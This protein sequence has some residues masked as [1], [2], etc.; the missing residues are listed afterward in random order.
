MA[1]AFDALDQ[2]IPGTSGPLSPTTT[3]QPAPTI[4]SLRKAPPPILNIPPNED[5]LLHYLTSSLMKNGE[6]Q[7]AARITA[8]TL[9]Y[10]HTFTRAPPLPI[11]RE[12]II[13]ASPAIRCFSTTFGSKRVHTP[14]ALSEKQR[15]RFGVEWILK[16]SES[17][18][19]RT[20]E[21]RLAREMVAVV[22]GT[23]DALK[24]KEEAH[25]F[26]MVNRGNLKIRM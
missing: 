4:S 12:A 19:G 22:Q 17:K 8:N 13:A 25:K 23:S 18:S 20:L 26:G 10:I 15:T 9:L 24:K 14:V 5:P 1:G 2:I 11:L 6:R 21:E 7:K 16:A 3:S